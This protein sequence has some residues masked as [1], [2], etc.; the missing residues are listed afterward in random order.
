MEVD[1]GDGYE[2]ERAREPQI[3]S[4]TNGSEPAILSITARAL[5]LLPAGAK[6]RFLFAASDDGDDPQQVELIRFNFVATLT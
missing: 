3:S 1:R 5:I 4:A 2:V 6:I